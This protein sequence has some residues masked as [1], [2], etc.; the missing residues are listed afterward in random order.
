MTVPMPTTRR[1]VEVLEGE[2]TRARWAGRTSWGVSTLFAILAVGTLGKG[3][4]AGLLFL[5]L[6]IVS[7]IRSVGY[8]RSARSAQLTVDMARAE[9]PDL[10]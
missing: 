1:G 10:R 7:A 6:G 3:N 2:I 8:G 5:V 9:H 4:P